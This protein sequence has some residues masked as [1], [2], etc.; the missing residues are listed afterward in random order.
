M[1][2]FVFGG[3]YDQHGV[4][5]PA[6]FYEYIAWVDGCNGFWLLELFFQRVGAAVFEHVCEVAVEGCPR[7]GLWACGLAET[8]TGALIGIK[9]DAGEVVAGVEELSAQPH[10][11]VGALLQVFVSD[12]DVEY[13]E[14]RLLIAFRGAVIEIDGTVFF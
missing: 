10:D 2:L 3:V 13:G 12:G 6:A 11:S 9:T 7:S 8:K 1:S 5:G 14:L 4:T